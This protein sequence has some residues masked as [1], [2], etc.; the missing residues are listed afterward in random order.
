MIFRVGFRGEKFFAFG[1]EALLLDR[2]QGEGGAGT[3]WEFVEGDGVGR[4]EFL[5]P[6]GEAEDAPALDGDPVDAGHV[7][8]GD[9]AFDFEE[10]GV[11]FWTGG[12]GDHR[13]IFISLVAVV[14][15]EVDESEHFSADGLVANPED[16]VGSP[17][18]GL[19][20]VREGEDIGAYAFG[21]DG[22]RPFKGDP[23]PLTGA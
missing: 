5:F 4:A 16:E 8:G 7:G 17:L 13:A 11:A 19:D 23:L 6:L 22:D 12:V 3:R 10:F 15:V 14:A 2:W 9:D 18:H 1:D 21:V 20:R